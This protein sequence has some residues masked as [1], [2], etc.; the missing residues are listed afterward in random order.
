[1]NESRHSLLPTYVL[2]T[3]A[4]N[5]AAFIERTIIS[6]RAQTYPPLRWVIVSDGSTDGTDD[7]VRRYAADCPWM[8]LMRMP[9]RSDRHFA[10]KAHAVNAAYARIRD[11][12]FDVFANLDAD[13]LFNETYFADLL[14]KLD[15][16]PALGIVGSAYRERGI[17]AYD[18]RFASDDNVPGP[19][20]LFR[21]KCFEDI[22]GYMPLKGGGID[23]VALLSARFKGWK[24]K[25]FTS[26]LFDHARPMGTAGRAAWT[27]GFFAGIK[28]YLVGNHPL[29]QFFRVV[30]QTTKMPVILG[31]LSLGTG[32][33]WAALW[34]VN[35]QVPSELIA[36]HRGEQM[37]R[38]RRLFAAFVLAESR[39]APSRSS[40]EAGCTV[41]NRG[42]DRSD[43]FNN[44]VIGHE[45]SEF[46]NIASNEKI[47]KLPI[48]VLIT[49]ARNEREAIEVTLKS[50]IAQTVPPLR[51]VVVSDGST[52]GTDDVVKKYAADYPWIELMQ[53]PDLGQRDFGR[54]A[55][56]VN[57][58]YARI[59]DLQFQVIC[60]LDADISVDEGHFAYL[61]KR[62]AED[63]ALGLVGTPYRESE[64]EIYDYRIVGL[65]HVS[66]ACQ[67]FRRQCFEDINGYLPVKGGGVDRIAVVSARLKG[68]RTRTFTEKVCV[69]ARPMGRAGHSI[70]QA[71]FKLGVKD[72]SLGS[73]PL[74]EVLRVLYQMRHKPLVL[75]GL[76][77]GAG[78]VSALIRQIERPVS[79][80]FVAFQRHDQMR[81][82]KSLLRYKGDTRRG[83]LST[84]A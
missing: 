9:E 82:L 49:A 81:R 48:Y 83:N 80:E 6:V 75:G 33:L 44:G 51:W 45:G 28:D 64:S 26:I 77:I 7:I 40:V 53:L 16:D 35:R 56:A 18:Y 67:M 69:H 68:W 10:G 55:L 2:A 65:D 37:K 12:Q 50:V 24:T 78:Y 79:R 39:E 36:F 46:G 43:M 25:A 29:W 4:R 66:G 23:H 11:L 70:L 3:S 34:R 13:V 59:R 74:W 62:L 63:P 84:L 58:A 19:C 54:K 38:L 27:A 73:H 5:E 32:Y 22:G 57:A 52:D 8:E 47:V 20:Q 17:R 31:G 60:N 1:M 72:Y 71:R 42:P 30:H 41:V 14:K 15:E 21:R 76:T 61:L